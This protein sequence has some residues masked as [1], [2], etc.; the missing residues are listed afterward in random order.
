MSLGLETDKSRLSKFLCF[1]RLE[2]V[3]VFK[4]NQDDVV[5]R[6]SSKRI[7]VNQVGIRCRFC[8][9]LS[10]KGRAGRSSTYPSSL[11]GIYQGVSMMIY[12]HFP[13]CD[14]MPV[15]LKEKYDRLKKLTKRGDVESRSYW[16]DAAKEK[17]L[18]DTSP[19]G[20][21]DGLSGMGIRFVRDI[22]T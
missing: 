4:A 12:E 7:H 6:L 1:L 22:Q 3:E 11:S 10:L 17:G 20:D 16:I 18:I 9:H 8:A 19:L 13:K 2:C 21:A 5:E 15:E 14:E